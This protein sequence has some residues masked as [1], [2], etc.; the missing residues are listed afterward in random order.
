[1]LNTVQESI[2]FEKTLNAIVQVDFIFRR[3]PRRRLNSKP[4]G[5]LEN[6]ISVKPVL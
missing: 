4:N 5:I 3:T 2:Y 6:S 1:M